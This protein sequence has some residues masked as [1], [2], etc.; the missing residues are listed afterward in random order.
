MLARP[1][2][3]DRSVLCIDPKGENARITARARARFGPVYVL[4]PFEISG[5]PSAAFNPSPASTPTGRTW[6]KTPHCWPTPW[7]MIL[8]AKSAILLRQGAAP[9]I[10]AKVRYY[11]G[12]E[13]RGLF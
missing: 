10:A 2:A 6:R 3:A 5:Q 9:A 13:F 12:A 1:W 4:D 11:D 7:S 8:R